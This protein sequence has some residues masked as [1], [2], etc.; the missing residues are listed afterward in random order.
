[1]V[2]S[3]L[4]VFPRHKTS[5]RKHVGTCKLYDFE[6]VKFSGDITPI[7]PQHWHLY[8]HE[9]DLGFIARQ[10]ELRYGRHY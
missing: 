1:M 9:D 8:A 7:P 6:L 5:A 3:N 2:I 4:V 10:L